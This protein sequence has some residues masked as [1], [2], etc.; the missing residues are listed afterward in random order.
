MAYPYRSELKKKFVD[1][2]NPYHPFDIESGRWFYHKHVIR[3]IKREFESKPRREVIVLQG[4]IGSGKSITLKRMVEDRSILGEKYIPVFIEL[5]EIRYSK[6]QSFLLAVYKKVR[7]T[8]GLF[9]F[10]IEYR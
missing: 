9:G 10:Q 4:I 6:I 7:N 8:L 2:P 5:P 3:Q 1:I